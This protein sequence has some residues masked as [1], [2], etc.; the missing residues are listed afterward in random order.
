MLSPYHPMQGSSL[1]KWI[2]RMSIPLKGCLR[3][4]LLIKKQRAATLVLRLGQLRKSMIIYDY[5]MH[6]LV[7]QYCPNHGIEISSQTVQQMVDRIME[8]PE[9]TRIQVLA[10]IVSG[11]KGA[12]VKVLEQIKKEGF[13]RFAV[14]GEMMEVTD[15]IEL[16][17]NKKH[18]IEVVVDRII[19]KDGVETRLTDSLETA[20]KLGQGRVLVD[21]IGKEE[22]LFS[23]L[24]SCPI[25]GFSI[26]ELE[27]RM[28]SFNSPFGACPDCDGIGWKMEVDIDLVIPDWNYDIT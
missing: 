7:V 21:I 22:L 8:Y 9:R 6:G 17:K 1:G 4:F 12:H 11:K 3:Q 16:D 19:V 15:E 14:D 13:V 18:S 2:N 5:F 20:L 24:H 23:E 25:C 10:P 26:G 27:P 28:F